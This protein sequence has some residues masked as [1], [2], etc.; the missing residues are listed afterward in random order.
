MKAQKEC[1]MEHGSI[2]H[3]TLDVLRGTIGHNPLLVCDSP[4]SKEGVVITARAP[5][6]YLL[7]TRRIFVPIS[8]HRNRPALYTRREVRPCLRR[9]EDSM[10]R[11]KKTKFQKC[12]QKVQDCRVFSVPPRGKH[13]PLYIN[14]ERSLV[15][16]SSEQVPGRF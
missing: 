2:S 3:E 10:L 9:F 1:L 16:A 7:M 8:S 12:K 5:Q 6:K 11:F 13:P 14:R 15:L 4:R